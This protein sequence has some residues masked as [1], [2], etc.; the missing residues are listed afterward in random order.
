[1][2]HESMKV[3]GNNL[4]ERILS[5]ATMISDISE[6]GFEYFLNTPCQAWDAVRYHEVWE[7]KKLGLDKVA[8]TRS[9]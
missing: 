1:M 4:T 9:I 6:P 8:L 5:F 7:D 2:K 3:N